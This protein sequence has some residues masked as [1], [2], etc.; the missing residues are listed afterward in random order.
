AIPTVLIGVA[1]LFF[2]TD[3]PEKAHWLSAAQRG[4]L[5]GSMVEERRIIQRE[6]KLGMLRAFFDPKIILLSLNYLGIVTA[7]LGMLLFLPQIVK[8]LG[9]TNMQVG[10]ASMIPY[11][12]GAASMVFCGWLSDRMGERRWSLF[13]TCMLSVV[14]LVI[15][16]LGVG[17]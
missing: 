4:W 13:C 1:V 8:Q 3:R 15:A 14:G 2:M 16:G 6:H 9:V 10:W 17:T 7:S 11:L 5:V 12:C